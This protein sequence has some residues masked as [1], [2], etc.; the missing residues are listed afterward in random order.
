MTNS[1]LLKLFLE[2]RNKNEAFIYKYISIDLG[3]FPFVFCYK[4]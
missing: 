3:S 4:D 1:K 2:L